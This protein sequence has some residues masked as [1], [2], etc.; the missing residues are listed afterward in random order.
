[1]A[2]EWCE[3]LQAIIEEKEDDYEVYEAFVENES[4]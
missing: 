1:M 4:H 2:I 3:V